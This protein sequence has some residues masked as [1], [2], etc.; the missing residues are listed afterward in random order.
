MQKLSAGKFHN[1]APHGRVGLP[2]QRVARI[3]SVVARPVA[4]VLAR[5][6]W[7][8][9]AGATTRIVSALHR[10]G[11]Y[12]RDATNASSGNAGTVP[13]RV[14]NSVSETTEA[15]LLTSNKSAGNHLPPVRTQASDVVNRTA[16][17]SSIA[18]EWCLLIPSMWGCLRVDQDRC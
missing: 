9:R 16:W 4:R 2:Y 5:W 11:R 10:T 12:S 8:E 14:E 6:A 1:D 17:Q 7:G 18:P 13:N 3:A 15:L